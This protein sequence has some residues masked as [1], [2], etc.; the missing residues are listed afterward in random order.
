ML[1][2][3]RKL[4]Q[5]IDKKINT[6]TALL[7]Y[8]VVIYARAPL[9]L[10]APRL[11]AEEGSVYLSHALNNDPIVTFVAQHL[12]YYSLF[13]KL[14]VVTAAYLI[15]LEYAALVT[16]LFSA[17]L[18]ISTC[19]VIYTSAGRLAIKKLHKFTLSLLPILLSTPET[20]LNTIN[21]QFW[22][23]TG[24]YFILNT[25]YVSRFHLIYLLLAFNTGVS[26][27]FFFPYFAIRAARQ[28]EFKLLLITFIGGLAGLIQITAF[29]NSIGGEVGNR[30][31]LEYLLNI[32][33]GLIATS[34]PFATLPLNLA[35]AIFIGFAIYRYRI[36]LIRNNDQ[37]GL[38]YSVISLMTYAILSVIASLSMSGGGRYGLPMYCGLAAIVVCSL[39]Q[40]NAFQNLRVYTYSLV[41]I[42]SF[43][44]FSFFNMTSVYSTDW[45]KWQEQIQR[46]PCH[47]AH[48]IH[49]FPQWEGWKWDM[50]LPEGSGVQCRSQHPGNTENLRN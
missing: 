4:A 31:R 25:M 8:A 2:L 14:A 17:A 37:I 41:F 21:G 15:P 46:A 42:A 9:F 27:L 16:T 34:L 35:Y 20:W 32:P 13:N 24:T 7:A 44:V 29:L 12:G 43:K 22:L 39:W 3:K 49:I 5:A 18:Q 33:Q 47:K 40:P 38:I 11:W 1:A 36:M 19:Y 30:F 45:P 23:A 26:S 50:I 10:H 28:K 48:K 6:Y